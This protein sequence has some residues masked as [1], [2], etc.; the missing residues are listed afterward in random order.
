M[1]RHRDPYAGSL[2][3]HLGLR[4]SNNDACYIEVD[5]MRRGWRDGEAM[6]FDETFVHEA[7]NDSNVNRLILFCDVERP[8]HGWLPTVLNR[9]VINHVLK[10]TATQNREGEHIGIAN[11][12]FAPVYRVRI[13]FKRLKKWNRKAYYGVKYTA[14]LVVLALIFLR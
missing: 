12:I 14:T 2:R 3:Y 5:G 10:V 1:G 6:M 9:F 4:T 13:L 7:K 8:L 11:R